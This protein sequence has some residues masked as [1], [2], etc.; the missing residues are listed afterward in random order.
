MVKVSQKLCLIEL[1]S[2]KSSKSEF[3]KYWLPPGG[4]NSSVSYSLSYILPWLQ[5]AQPRK[6]KQ[7]TREDGSYTTT[8]PTRRRPCTR[9]WGTCSIP[10]PQ[11]PGCRLRGRRLL[12]WLVR[13]FF[14][15]NSSLEGS[16]GTR[17]QQVPKRCLL[18]F[19]KIELFEGWLGHGE[20]R[21]VHKSY[22]N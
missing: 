21:T 19:H 18:A 16:L 15:L 5:H 22:Y 17:W 20:W 3:F 6:R 2:F 8:T 4:N 7:P 10:V 13:G 12:L 9:E 1:F 11:D 14:N